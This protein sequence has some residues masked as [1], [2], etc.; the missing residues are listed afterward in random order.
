MKSHGDSPQYVNPGYMQ[1]PWI[2][3][4]MG[5]ENLKR[6]AKLTDFEAEKSLGK[7]RIIDLP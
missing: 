7:G 3:K 6:I 4:R 1:E 2:E 5:F